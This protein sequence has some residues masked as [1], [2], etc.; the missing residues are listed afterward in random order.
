MAQAGTAAS[1]IVPLIWML[2]RPLG[3]IP[4]PWASSRITCGGIEDD[5]DVQAVFSNEEFSEEINAARD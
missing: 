1:P 4:P 5:D 2:A 3:K